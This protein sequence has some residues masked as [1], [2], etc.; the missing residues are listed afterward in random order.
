MLDNIADLEAA[1]SIL[2]D[3]ATGKDGLVAA[4]ARIRTEYD[5]LRT[6][7]SR[8]GVLTGTN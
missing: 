8:A 6:D 7:L 5:K 1:V 4:I 2:P 3:E